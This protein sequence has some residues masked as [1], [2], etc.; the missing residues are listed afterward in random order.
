MAAPRE[1]AD[2]DAPRLE[3][4]AAAIASLFAVSPLAQALFDATGCC[5]AATPE[6]ARRAAAAADS[7]GRL[8]T[9]FL[10][11]ADLRDLAH[12]GAA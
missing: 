3:G 1:P 6:F 9:E 7:A 4:A 11:T 5:A 12:D 10:A 2:A 8:S